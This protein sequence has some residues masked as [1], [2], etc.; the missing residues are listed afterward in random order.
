L[1]RDNYHALKAVTIDP[2]VHRPEDGATIPVIGTAHVWRVF[3]D[4]DTPAHVL[5]YRVLS[6]TLHDQ[7]R[8]A[9]GEWDGVMVR[10]WVGRWCA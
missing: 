9:L 7:D 10:T 4:Y 1:S 2:V 8:D 3:E 5:A 6:A